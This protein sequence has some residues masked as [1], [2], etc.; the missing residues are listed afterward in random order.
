VT[1]VGALLSAWLIPAVTRQWQD[2]QKARELKASL[3]SRISRD[4]TRA[5][6]ASD[7][8]AYGRF[9]GTR[10]SNGAPPFSDKQFNDLDITWRQNSEEVE[11]LLA[12]YF[13]HLVGEWHRYAALVENTYFLLRPRVY[14]RAETISALLSLHAATAGQAALLA[15]P[16]MDL[17][18]SD[19]RNAYFLVTQH[20]L[21]AKKTLVSHILHG[22]ADGYSQGPRDFLHDLLPLV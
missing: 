2:Q 16:F 13:P 10:Q 6:V 4:A 19:P 15:K 11:G 5:L 1:V 14:L 18:S 17:P 22:H 9:G 21:D 7:F 20:L 12:A 3:V 8:V